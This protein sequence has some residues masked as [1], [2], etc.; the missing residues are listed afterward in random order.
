MDIKLMDNPL[1][2][3]P[4]SGRVWL[5]VLLTCTCAG[6]A[7]VLWGWIWSLAP[8]ILLVFMICII[9]PVWGLYVLVCS[10]FFPYA[11]WTGVTTYPADVILFLVVIGFWLHRAQEGKPGL[12]RTPV[13]LPVAVWL[14]ILALSLVNA[15]DLP[16]GI[17]NWLRHVQL[18]LLFYAVVGL[19]DARTA[20]RL[21]G[22]FIAVATVFALF[23]IFPFIKSGGVERVFGV[24][25]VPIS[26]ILTLVIVYL[27]ARICFE[28][29][30]SRA[31]VYTVLL[32]VA[33]MGQIANQSRAAIAVSV[34]G[35]IIALV[36]ASRWGRVHSVSL[37]RS[38]VR[39]FAV[40]GLILILIAATVKPPFLET[41]IERFQGV[42]SAATTLNYRYFLW[43]TAF[44]SYLANPVLGLGLAQVQ[45][46]HHMIAT[47]RFDPIG[48]QTFGL[49]THLAFLKYLAETGTVGVV[50]L[51]WLLAKFAQTGFLV[52]RRTK[53]LTHA[54]HSIGV[55]VLVWVIILRSFI[56]GYLFYSTWGMTNA[57][58]FGFLINMFNHRQE[59]E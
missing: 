22:L 31:R 57:L 21:M 55:C 16:R 58:F 9:N 50:A 26:G 15:Y 13:D 44:A 39:V 41:V 25:R 49:G 38:R 24:A 29:R 14:G 1:T 3:S 32:A 2:K 48:M 59:Q 27:T 40:V 5:G 10:L 18:F 45:V 47:L 56:E 54:G 33:I 7:G 42:G 52:I 28:H 43:K 51:L 19:T 36:V 23:N 35:I 12:V 53:R 34:V 11:I 30:T 6:V 46:W 17:V 4:I 37:P 8:I 20:K